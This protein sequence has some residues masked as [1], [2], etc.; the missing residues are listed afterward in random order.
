VPSYN[1]EKKYY[2]FSFK[3]L[4]TM[5]EVFDA[6]SRVKAECNKVSTMSLFQPVTKSMRLEEFEQAQSQATAQVNF[7][8]GSGDQDPVNPYTLKGCL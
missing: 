8:L 4:L 6:I 3:S 7:I 5:P 2:N 1:F